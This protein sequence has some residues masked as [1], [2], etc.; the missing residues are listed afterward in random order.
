MNTRYKNGFTMIEIVVVIAI[1]GILAGML[2]P[3]VRGYVGTA[4]ERRAE[5]DTEALGKAMLAFNRD[6]A[7]F[8]IYQSGSAT[9]PTDAVFVALVTSEGA[10][11][12]GGADGWN[13]ATVDTFEDQLKNNTV[14]YPTTGEFAWRGPYIGPVRKDP[15]GNRYVCNASKLLPTADNA[16]WVL[17]AGPNEVIETTFSQTMGSPTIGGDDIAYR[18]K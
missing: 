10:A 3:M 13:S 18:I 6:T 1:I 14:S 5:Q 9:A 7:R 2:V 4:K 8:P 12:G 16:A 15:W 11:P 17:S